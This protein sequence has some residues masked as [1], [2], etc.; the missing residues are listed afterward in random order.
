MVDF[1]ADW[2]PPCRVLTPVLEKIARGLQGEVLLAK[3]EVDENMHL[4]GRYKLRG[5]PT[6][7]LFA[8]GEEAGRFTGARSEQQVHAFLSD[9]L[10][11]ISS[12][13]ANPDGAIRS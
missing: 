5:F 11:K 12:A 9:H 8:Q 6:V 7:I 13:G 2:C 4:A 1:W 10:P 3:V